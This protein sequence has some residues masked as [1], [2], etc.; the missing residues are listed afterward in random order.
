MCSYSD[1]VSVLQDPV[2]FSGT[3]RENLDPEGVYCSGDV[4]TSLKLSGLQGWV[5]GLEVRLMDPSHTD[6]IHGHCQSAS[7]AQPRKHV[8]RLE[9]PLTQDRLKRVC[10]LCYMV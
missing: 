3:L 5:D 6:A 2:I 7:K 9:S 8:K 10:R 4:V 1:S